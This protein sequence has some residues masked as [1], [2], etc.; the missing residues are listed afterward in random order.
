MSNKTCSDCKS[1]PGMGYY[2]PIVGRFCD[3][4]N[5]KPCEFFEKP[6][7]RIATNGDVIRQM[8]N[9]ELAE[10]IV[11]KVMFCDGCPVKCEEKDIPQHRENP[12]G[13]DVAEDVCKKRVESWLNALADC[14]KQNGVDDTQTDLRKADYTESEV[15]NG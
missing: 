4:N 9:A 15:D 10:L 6:M 12:F 8:S 3:P 7:G 1:F 14:V 11:P 5:E 2:C 13:A